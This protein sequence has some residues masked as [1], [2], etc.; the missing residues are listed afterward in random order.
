MIQVHYASMATGSATMRTATSGIRAE[1]ERL[2]DAQNKVRG[3]WNGN[4][5]SQF[6]IRCARVQAKRDDIDACIT[7]H[8]NLIDE[9]SQATN[10]IDT[11]MASLFE[12]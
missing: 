1:L 7:G 2:K 9:V 4:S 12:T 3:T 5:Q 6:D 10:Q 8:A 11:R